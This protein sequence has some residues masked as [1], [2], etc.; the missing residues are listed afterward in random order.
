MINFSSGK[1]FVFDNDTEKIKAHISALLSKTTSNQSNK[2]KGGKSAASSGAFLD[3]DI[4]TYEH[5]PV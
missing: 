3:A 1:D 5:L 4:F 2:K